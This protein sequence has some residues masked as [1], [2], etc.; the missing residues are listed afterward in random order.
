MKDHLPNMPR[1]TSDPDDEVDG[2]YEKVDRYDAST[3]AELAMRFRD[4]LGLIGEDPQREGLL[5]TPE[6]AGKA[7]QFLTHGYGLD[8]AKILRS[9]M[10]KED[11]REM[12]IVKDIELY[13]TKKPATSSLSP[14]GRSKGERLVSAS[15]EMNMMTNIGNSGMMNHMFACARTISVRFSEPTQSSTVTMTKP[16]ETS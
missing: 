16:I 9:A 1:P 3:T 4:A 13:S 14:S 10:F 8:A 12:L 11:Y 5:K 15:A 7:L 6:R 2:G